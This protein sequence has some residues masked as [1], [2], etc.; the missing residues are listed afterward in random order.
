MRGGVQG[1]REGPSAQATHGEAEVTGSHDGKNAAVD[2][3]L[4]LFV[5]GLL[6]SLLRADLSLSHLVGLFLGFAY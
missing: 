2:F 1:L 3:S 6:F 4:F 5:V